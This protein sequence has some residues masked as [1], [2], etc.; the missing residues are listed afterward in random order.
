MLNEIVHRT[1]NDREASSYWLELNALLFIAGGNGEVSLDDSRHHASR[2][3]CFLLRANQSLH[4]QNGKTEPLSYFLIIFSVQQD[5]AGLL[6]RNKAL[7]FDPCSRLEDQ[8]LELLV[9]SHS[10]HNND[11][12]QLNDFQLHIRFQTM[13]YD[14]LHKLHSEKQGTENARQAVERTIDYL[15]R[16]YREE[17]EIGR[18]AREANMSR[19]QYGSLFKSLTGQTPA[20]YLN[21]LRIEQAKTLLASSSARINDI[22]ARVGF[23]DEYY[24]SRR[25]KQ[26]TGMSPTQFAHSRGRSPRIFSIQYLGSCWRS[27]F[28]RSERTAPCCPP[29]R[30]RV[31][32]SAPSTNR[33]T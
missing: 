10:R 30:K 8:L 31:R 13:L 6:A 15:H 27:A 12:N 16:A 33:S 24:F 21:A 17:I 9:S 23:R 22:A 19:W 28:A 32:M 2:G 4:L 29:C 14:V 11:E 5:T 18:L 20:R 25:F 3:K 26:T 7:V 1:T